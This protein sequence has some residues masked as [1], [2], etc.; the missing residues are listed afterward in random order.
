MRCTPLRG[1]HIRPLASVLVPLRRHSHP[2]VIKGTCQR[3][4]MVGTEEKPIASSFRR[5]RPM[6]DSL[7]P[8]TLV[9]MHPEGAR[10]EVSHAFTGRLPR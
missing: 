2:A 8:W 6:G 7:Y 1:V 5:L 9:L 10:P 3:A 4:T